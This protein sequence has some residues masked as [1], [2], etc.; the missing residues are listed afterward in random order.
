M[1]LRIWLQSFLHIMSEFLNLD[2][3]KKKNLPFGEIVAGRLRRMESRCACL[4]LMCSA[5]ILTALV[6]PA[7]YNIPL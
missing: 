3:L 5:L 4:V 7:L 1:R 6:G 2:L